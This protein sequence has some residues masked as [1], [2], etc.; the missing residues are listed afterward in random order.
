[1]NTLT[2]LQKRVKNGDVVVIPRKEYEALLTIKQAQEFIPTAA[3]KK[4]LL[5]AERNFSQK[6]TFSYNELVK[7]LESTN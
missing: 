4:A 3:E 7:K 5:N 6:K 1:M 2:I